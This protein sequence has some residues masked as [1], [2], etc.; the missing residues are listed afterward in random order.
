MKIICT[1]EGDP[2]ERLDA[3]LEAFPVDVSSTTSVKVPGLRK[4]A[5]IYKVDTEKSPLIPEG[6][7]VGDPFIIDTKP[8]REI[9]CHPHLV[10]WELGVLCLDGAREFH[11]AVDGLSMIRRDGLAIL[12]ILRGA[13]AYR[14]AEVMQRWLP[15]LSV[16]T[17]YRQDGYRSHT[18]REI[19]VTFRDYSALDSLEGSVETLLIP[20]TYATGRSAEAALK[21]L[22]NAG[23]EPSKIVLYG[24]I[25]IPALIRLGALTSEHGIELVSFAICDI[26]QLA[27]NDYDMP[28]YGLDESLCQATGDLSHL[29]SIVDTETLREMITSYVVGLDQPGD[30]S[31]RHLSL[32]DGHDGREGDVVGHLRKSLGLIESL[33]GINS[34]QPWYDELHDSIAL[35]EMEE[36][37]KALLRYV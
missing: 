3:I 13:P 15:T 24:F 27:H 25:A 17:E 11:K 29:G 36:I 7:D 4:D 6:A 16:R 18:E 34:G 2:G 26:A 21:D 14:L 30:W 1:M 8:G 9:A 10:G 28:L 5:R 37:E 32:F 22:F 33:R 20:D 23:V 19:G 35:K 12:H 31:E